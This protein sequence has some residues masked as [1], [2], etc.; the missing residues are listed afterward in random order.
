MSFKLKR[1]NDFI[2]GVVLSNLN[3]WVLIQRYVDYRIDG[4]CI[5]KS[6]LITEQVSGDKEKLASKIIKKKYGVGTGEGPIKLTNLEEMLQN[7]QQKYHL[8]Q[9]DNKKGDA[10]DVVKY[11]GAE[12]SLYT[13][14][15]LTIN[16]KWRFKLR[17]PS[18]EFSVISF[19]N[20]YLD[21]LLLII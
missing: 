9:L 13:F 14:R 20:D 5:I 21:S 10:F 12:K 16:G 1:R 17:L 4:Y 15:E 6:D 2:S 3:G 11:L 7:I 18:E 8:I 19:N